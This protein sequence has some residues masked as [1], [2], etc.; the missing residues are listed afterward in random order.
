MSID[1]IL[2]DFDE[3]WAK[4]K[5]PD[6]MSYIRGDSSPID[7]DLAWEIIQRDL[8]WRLHRRNECD[9]LAPAI[10]RYLSHPELSLPPERVQKLAALEEEWRRSLSRK[11]DECPAPQPVAG[12]HVDLDRLEKI[13]VGGMGVIYRHADP[14]LN[15]DVA[16]KVLQP[17]LHPAGVARFL[18]EAHILA[19]LEH[20]GIVPIHSLGRLR[21]GR[22][23][24]TMKIVRGQTLE[25]VLA[26]RQSPSE[27]LS[28]FI[29]IFEQICQ[30]MAYAH[31]KQVLHRDLKSANV[32]IG[33]FGEIQ[34]MDWGLGKASHSHEPAAPASLESNKDATRYGG[35]FGTYPFMA[36]DQARGLL[37]QIDQRSDVFGLGGILCEI[38][39]GFPPYC[40]P[41]VRDKA[42][43]GDLHET[44]E[45]LDRCGAEPE[46][47]RI[48]RACLQADPAARLRDA[49][50]VAAQ[51]AAYRSSVEK[52]L[53]EARI[54]HAKA[55]EA[56]RRLEAEQQARV[57]EA[58]RTRLRRWAFGLGL[59]LAAVVVIAMVIT[60]FWQNAAAANDAATTALGQAK[61][62][63]QRLETA[64]Q[65][66]NVANLRLD[67]SHRALEESLK[68]V[69]SLNDKLGH[70]SYA[71][72]IYLAR[73]AIQS[74][75]VASARQLLAACDKRYRGW[76]WRHLDLAFSPEL[77]TLRGHTNTPRLVAFSQD[78]ARLA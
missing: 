27:N 48:A 47:M 69:E 76:E 15:R 11:P 12:V 63:N 73:V 3:S 7:A 34:V 28:H 50:E 72:Q 70:S 55:E 39:T 17:E 77:L 66:T 45:R 52:R 65:A 59:V 35:A 24:F 40:D 6:W 57:A 37:D 53:A 74:G 4:G 9:T 44:Y 19:Q 18:K 49:G 61:V 71:H 67:K 33:A 2:D 26:D 8:Y 5:E 13:G 43:A 31:A 29:D 23:F 21:D 75:E 54:E 64:N 62:A 10:D 20:P 1:K 42:R 38:L 14:D 36:P 46:L 41:A 16:I 32:M 56:K 60:S 51:V 78:G 68:Q 25:K 58:A 22:P 30:T